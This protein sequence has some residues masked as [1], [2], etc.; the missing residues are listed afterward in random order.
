MAQIARLG[1]VLGSASLVGVM[2][3]P[4]MAQS[5]DNDTLTVRATVGSECEVEGG[6]LDFG[7][8]TG[9]AKNGFATIKYDCNLPSDISIALSAGAS[10][11]E[12][13]R[14]M[15][16]EGNS[17]TTMEYQLYRNEGRNQVWGSAPERSVNEEGATEGEVTVFGHIPGN[18]TQVIAGTYSDVVTITLTSN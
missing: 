10:T 12:D 18:Q 1:W 4:A 2:A 3:G 6:T 15:V 16:H 9:E 7:S 13:Q 14:L 8:Y 17:T 11:V 5:T